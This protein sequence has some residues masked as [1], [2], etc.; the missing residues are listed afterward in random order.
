[1]STTEKSVAN[2]DEQVTKGTKRAS[3]VR[4]YYSFILSEIFGVDF[5]FHIFT[6]TLLENFA[7]GMVLCVRVNAGTSVLKYRGPIKVKAIYGVEM[8]ECFVK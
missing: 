8:C 6:P 5:L 2:A 7:V 4:D 3:E 1:M